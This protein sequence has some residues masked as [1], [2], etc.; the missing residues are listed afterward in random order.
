MDDHR[1]DNLTRR[2]ATGTSRR[3]FIKRLAGGSLAGALA[4]LRHRRSLADDKVLVCHRT[5][6]ATNPVV[7][8]KVSVNAIPAHQ[9]H[10]D[11]IDPDFSNDPAHCG[12]CFVG[13]GDEEVCVDGVCQTV[14]C[15]PLQEVCDST[16]NQ[17]CQ[18][19]P[20]ACENVTKPECDGIGV[21]R[22]CHALGSCTDDCDC[23]GDLFCNDFGICDNDGLD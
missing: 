5:S 4:A 21:S 2:L 23:C 12:G 15:L 10:G 17:C 14:A 1:F 7:V 11:A 22:C 19:E 8:I 9:A 6:S 13:C 18:N 3:G 20:T 16:N